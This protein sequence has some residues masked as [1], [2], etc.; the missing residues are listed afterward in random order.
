MRK[1]G[2][3]SELADVVCLHEFCNVILLLDI[4]WNVEPNIQI[5]KQPD[6]KNNIGFSENKLVN[7]SY[8]SYWI[9]INLCREQMDWSTKTKESTNSSSISP[10]R[11][12]SS[13]LSSK[14]KISTFSSKLNTSYLSRID[15]I[16]IFFNSL[17]VPVRLESYIQQLI[18][19]I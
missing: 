17:L 8:K 16:S 3:K 13:G 4:T 7:K 2:Q 14:S 5:R 19:K 6:F 11:H 1:C 9:Y 12:A 18:I 15:F 10:I